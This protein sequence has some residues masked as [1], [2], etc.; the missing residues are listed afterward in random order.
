MA[1]DSSPTLQV[2]V[3]CDYPASYSIAWN[4]APRE[5]RIAI[6]GLVMKQAAQ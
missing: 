2:M 6:D 3:P 4:S 5:Y 1:R